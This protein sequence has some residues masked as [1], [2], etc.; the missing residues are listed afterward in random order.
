MRFMRFFAVLAMMLLIVGGSNLY[1]ARRFYQFLHHYF[2]NL[3]FL[4][5]IGLFV[6]LLLVLTLGFTRSMLP[7]PVVVK[8]ALGV[9]NAYWMGVFI[10]LL[11]FFLLADAA[12]LLARLLGTPDRFYF[13]AGALILTAAVCGYGFFHATDIQQKDYDITIPGTEDMTVVMISDVH[14]GAVG[15]EKRLPEIVEKI[16]ELEPDLVCIAGDFFDSDFSAIRD[17][18]AAAA[19]LKTLNPTYGV[20]ACLGNHDAGSTAEQMRDFLDQCGIGLLNDEYTVIADKLVLAGRMDRSP[21]GGFGGLSGAG[22]DL[23]GVDPALPVVVMDHNPAYIG[24]YGLDVDLIL[25]GHTHRGQIFPG[26]LITDRM[27]TVDYGYYR[28]D[29][30]SPQ[31]IVSSGVGYWGMPMRVGTDCEIVKISIHS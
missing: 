16:N 15:S 11:I 6:L 4:V 19:T 18:D 17:P 2:P 10:Y 13:L 1:L 31:V 8:R 5:L 21:I 3:P 20:W 12:Y 30:D 14:L 29:A 22:L 9:A 7:L 23:T 28:T 27:Y 24:E 26:S 25:S